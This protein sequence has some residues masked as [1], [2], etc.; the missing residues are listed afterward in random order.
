MNLNIWKIGTIVI[1]G[2]L[3]VGTGVFLAKFLRNGQQNS[4][5][6]SQQSNSNTSILS[7]II[8]SSKPTPHPAAQ[9]SLKLLRKM[10]SATEVGINFQEYGKRVI[11]LKADV[12]E[13]LAQLPESELKQEIKLAAEAYVDAGTAWNEM[14][15]YDFMLTSFEPARSFQKKYSIPGEKT[16]SRGGLRLDKNVVLSTIWGAARKHID[17]ATQLM[18]Q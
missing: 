5:S 16:D 8:P 2:L 4:Q 1:A 6:A 15:R 10:A 17:R 18:N 7:G 13:E 3:L 11:D 14:L 12:D 9:N